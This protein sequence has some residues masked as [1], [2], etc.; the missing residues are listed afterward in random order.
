VANYNSCFISKY[1]LLILY[2]RKSISYRWN[3]I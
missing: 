1:F 2:C 3:H